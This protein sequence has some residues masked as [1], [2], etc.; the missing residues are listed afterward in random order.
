[1]DLLDLLVHLV[2]LDHLV[3]MVREEKEE[4]KD[5]LVCLDSLVFRVNVVLMERLVKMVF[6]VF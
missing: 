3:K 6:Q 4:L 1:V 2:N 5:H